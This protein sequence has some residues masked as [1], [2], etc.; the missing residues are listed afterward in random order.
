V[1][2][3]RV[4]LVDENDDFLDGLTAWI[5][6]DPRLR[7]AGKAHSGHAALEQVERLHPDLALIGASLPD[8]NG[9]E[10]TRR[11]KSRPDAPRVVLLTFHESNAARLEAW[12]AGADAMV[13]KAEIPEKLLSVVQ[14]LVRRPAE[15][16][17]ARGSKRENEPSKLS[18][19]KPGPS[20]DLPE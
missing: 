10:T 16:S 13:S 4:L 2:Q 8:L 14:D 5:A 7:L 19:E 15:A 1:R 18:T 20:R 9:F 12:A 17:A 3:I 6:G 11:I